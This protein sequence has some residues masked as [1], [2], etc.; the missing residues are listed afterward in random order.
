MWTWSTWL[1]WKGAL[2]TIN[3]SF[4]SLYRE[5]MLGLLAHCVSILW[6][7]QRAAFSGNWRLWPVSSPGVGGSGVW[8]VDGGITCSP[9]PSPELIILW[10]NEHQGMSSVAGCTHRIGMAWWNTTVR[11][12]SDQKQYYVGSNV[13]IGAMCQQTGSENIKY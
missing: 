8:T 1:R 12:C 7:R 6:E 2:D 10:G 13:Q 11:L 5:A 9:L 4:K 3:W